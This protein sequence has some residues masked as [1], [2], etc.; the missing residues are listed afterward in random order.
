MA[1]SPKQMISPADA[2]DVGKQIAAL[3][4][5]IICPRCR[6]KLLF[7]RNT[8]DPRPG[9]RWRYRRCL[10]CGFTF[11]TEE[12]SPT[13]LKEGRSATGKPL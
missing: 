11:R 3:P 5:G 9:I 4:K 1:K 7:V 2:A 13:C 12:Q 6:S 10:A 8:R